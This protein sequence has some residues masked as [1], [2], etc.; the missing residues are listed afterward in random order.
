MKKVIILAALSL[1]GQTA[2][3]QIR[4]FQTSRL[5]STGGTGIASI[6]STEA[7]ILNPASS[8][9]FQ[10]SSF[11]YQSY[12][13][14]LKEEND[15]RDTAPDEF[16]DNNRSQ[17]AFLSD[18][19]SP[20]KGGVAYIQQNEN[21]YHRERMVLHG[22]APMGASSSVGLSY[23]YI[24]DKLPRGNNPR[25]E[26]HHQLLLGTTHIIDEDTILALTLKDPTRTTPGEER[27]A[28]G[29]Q[30]TLADR[31]TIMGDVGAQYTK[32][33][34]EEYFW[35]AAVQM[36][37]FSDFFLRVGQFYDNVTE[38]KGTGWGA[39]WIGPRFGVEF[40]Q[41]FSDQLS[42]GTYLYEDESIVDTS[43]SVILKF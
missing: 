36:N 35:R 4:D 6:L 38:F 14:K 39:S 7:A 5:I 28:A 11:A 34:N 23:S 41:Q 37:I 26:V 8:A 29:F 31:F 15:I 27:A 33:V 1:M 12:Q 40:A 21:D 13:T 16:A 32:A 22:A 10:G 25:H 20:V 19:S 9:F 43:F 2:W 24:Q 17:G 30:Y 18:H 3:A 42:E